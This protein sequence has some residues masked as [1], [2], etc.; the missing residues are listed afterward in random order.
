[1]VRLTLNSSSK[2]TKAG[3]VCLVYEGAETTKLVDESYKK[4]TPFSFLARGFG[5]LHTDNFYYAFDGGLKID[6]KYI[7]A[8]AERIFLGDIKRAHSRE[9]VF[10]TD[11]EPFIK[12]YKMIK[13]VELLPQITAKD[14]GCIRRA[15]DLI[16]NYERYGEKCFP[17]IESGIRNSFLSLVGKS[18]KKTEDAIPPIFRDV[19]ASGLK[20][21]LRSKPENLK[22]LQNGADI[23]VVLKGNLKS[24]FEDV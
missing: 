10:A 5:I 8:G 21:A 18:K 12:S 4:V 11:A 3:I 1:M 22:E 24:L 20:K 16:S 19:E 15:E 7:V 17:S 9:I 6:S 13:L 23:E 14:V 2:Y